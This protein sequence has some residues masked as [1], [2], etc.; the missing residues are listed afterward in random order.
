MAETA[1]IGSEWVG[2]LVRVL[3]VFRCLVLLAT[4]VLLPARQQ[5]GV[6]AL[7]VV[8][9]ALVSY[10][11]LRHW[12]RIGP[13]V[14]RHPAYLASEVLLATL[15][16]AAAGARSS[17]FYFTL[18]TAALAGIV[19]GR[20]GA[21]PFAALLIASYELVA[22]Y[23][24]PSFHPRLDAQTV[25]FMPLLYPA[26]LIAG[27]AARELV[28]RGI[29]MEA[30][31]R[32]RTEDLAS[33]R[34]RVRVARELHDSLA[35]TVEGLAMSAAM[36]P[37]RCERDPV[38]AARVARELA[39]D[40]RQAAVEARA[41]MSGLRAP[42]AELPLAEAVR[43]R[44]QSF[45]ERSGIAVRVDCGAAEGVRTA[46][47]KITHEFLRVLSEALVNAQRHGGASDVS[48]SLD[49]HDGVLSLSVCDNGSGLP[50][51]VDID[52]LKAAG[53]FGLAG[54]QERARTIGGELSIEQPADGGTRISIRLRSEPKSGPVAIA[55]EVDAD[56]FRMLRPS[57]LRRR[58]GRER[59]SA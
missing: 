2:R 53:H 35:K 45:G 43:R 48:V 57:L 21:L 26:A 37:A 32:A 27:V 42:A 22:L 16:L 12:D 15:I 56:R 41:L 10:V 33:E 29:Q 4:V 47:P 20:R 44:A 25:A 18:G 24:L 9:A 52:A 55:A 51:P 13:S 59:A 31:L 46:S 50:G 17:F 30:L 6:V 38:V 40:A 5:T 28:E 11:P 19:Y 8:L 36:L 14:S 23:G 1:N 34:E 7:A 49:D 54:M 39:D 58:S 3:L